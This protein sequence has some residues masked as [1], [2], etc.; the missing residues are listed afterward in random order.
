MLSRVSLRAR[1]ILGV[2]VLAAAGLAVADVATYTSLRSFLISRT[3]VSL[4]SAH[5]AVEGAFHG[6]GRGPHSGDGVDDR[7]RGVGVLRSGISVHNSA[8]DPAGV[9]FCQLMP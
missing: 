3:D 6:P 8:S 5:H 7:R 1:L 9:L 4:D 2:V